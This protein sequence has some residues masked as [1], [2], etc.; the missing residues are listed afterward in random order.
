M[1]IPG[2]REAR[3]GGEPLLTE[4]RIHGRTRWRGFPGARP[5][6]FLSGML[7]FFLGSE[8]CSQAFMIG[9]LDV[10]PQLGLEEMYDDNVWLRSGPEW[11]GP[12]VGDWVSRLRPG[13]S[14]AYDYGATEFSASYLTDF[15]FYA[16]PKSGWYRTR[17]DTYAQNNDLE[18]SARHE[19][20]ARTSVSL[21]DSLAIGTNV[22][23][24]V[25][26][27][28]AGT[29]PSGILPSPGDYRTN[30]ADLEFTRLLT[31]QVSLAIGAGYGYYWYSEILR[32]DP[33]LPQHVVVEEPDR[34]EN[35]GE[36][37]GTCSYAWHPRNTVS[38]A[39]MGTY[40]N[41]GFRGESMIGT[42]TLGDEWQISQEFSLVA[43][44]GGQYLDQRLED[45]PRGRG[46]STSLRPTGNLEFA[47]LV[48][49]FEFRLGGGYAMGDS[50]GQAATVQSR[51]ARFRASWEPLLDLT[52]E[53]FG[54]YSRDASADEAEGLDVES[55]QCGGTAAYRLFS[56]ISASFRYT[57]VDQNDLNLLPGT[58]GTSY[59]DNRFILGVVLLLPESWGETFRGGAGRQREPGGPGA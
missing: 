39:L 56:W 16:G 36:L 49:R 38:L 23:D 15:N 17:S 18:L 29:N 2:I 43:S 37:S 35:H 45:G 8:T 32:Y 22:A 40:M 6:V 26:G 46:T 11:A 53:G 41:F 33:A 3:N 31:R 5:F 58:A 20:G 34:E 14:L 9:R 50:S 57:Y 24:L 25:A 42:V 55:F 10:A 27:P 4:S 1:K 13:L 51:S 7:L 12:V 59:N 30:R 47:Y 19:F 52:L 48:Q 21:S 54:S 44:V 28:A